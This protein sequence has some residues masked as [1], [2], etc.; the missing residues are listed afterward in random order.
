MLARIEITN[1]KWDLGPAV[2]QLALVFFF[3]RERMVPKPGM[4]STPGAVF[5]NGM[6]FSREKMTLNWKFLVLS[7]FLARENRI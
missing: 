4:S 2:K 1:H 5:L 3:A 6:V 7:C